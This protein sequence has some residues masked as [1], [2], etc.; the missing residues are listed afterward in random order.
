MI[1]ESLSGPV[2]QNEINSFKSYILTINPVVY[3]DT[4]SIENQYAQAASGEQIKAMG[5]MYEITQDPAILDRMIFFCDAL[6]GQ[7]N[8][9]LAAPYGQ[10][11]YATGNIEPAWTGQRDDVT[12]Y[13]T[14]AS[15]DCVGLDDTQRT[16]HRH[17][18]IWL[19]GACPRECRGLVAGIDRGGFGRT[20]PRLSRV[21]GARF[22]G[23]QLAADPKQS[24]N[25]S[26]AAGSALHSSDTLSR[27]SLLLLEAACAV[28][29]FL[30]SRRP[31]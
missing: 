30:H 4:G 15:G 17:P 20:G 8:D 24:L 21:V 22:A 2:T 12:P 5:L 29:A 25:P 11:T 27:S 9:I 28:V 23:H 19:V 7:R 16:R 3:P 1:V 14:S 26:G 6:L 10:K 31:E 13:S 18:R